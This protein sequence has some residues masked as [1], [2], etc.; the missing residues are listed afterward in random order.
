MPDAEGV[1]PLG[2]IRMAAPGSEKASL[3]GPDR[4]TTG[5]GGSP[6]RPVS[7]VSV[8]QARWGRTYFFVG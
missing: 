1:H 2:V 7:R 6:P 3:A 8:Y 5:R 4:E